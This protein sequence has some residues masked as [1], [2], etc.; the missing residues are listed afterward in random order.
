MGTPFPN[1]DNLAQGDVNDQRAVHIAGVD[2][3]P[4][5]FSDS[6]SW[7]VMQGFSSLDRVNQ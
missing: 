5:L 4:A 1:K 2:Q 3:E 6:S 7:F